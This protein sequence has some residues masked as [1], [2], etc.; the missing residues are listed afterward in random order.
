MLI[1]TPSRFGAWDGQA[2]AFVRA[3]GNQHGVEALLE[4]VIQV[5]HAVVQAQIDAQ[6]DD[7]L[8]FALDDL[9]RQA[10]FRYTQAQHAARRPAWLRRRSPR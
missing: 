4:D 9:G 6:V 10:V 8:H 5:V 3:N 2:D 7:I 1:S